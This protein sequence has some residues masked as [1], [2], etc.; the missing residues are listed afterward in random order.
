MDTGHLFAQLAGAG[1]GHVL[2]DVGLR[3]NAAHQPVAIDLCPQSCSTIICA[4]S[5]SPVS[6]VQH[7]VVR[8]MTS[9]MRI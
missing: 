7:A 9:S 1:A 2:R 6:G 8:V 4:T 5:R 3:N